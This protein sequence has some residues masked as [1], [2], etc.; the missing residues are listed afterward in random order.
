MICI[1][2]Q[3]NMSLKLNFGDYKSSNQAP[4]RDVGVHEGYGGVIYRGGG[5]N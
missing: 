4:N 1:Y 2:E 3:S 5:T